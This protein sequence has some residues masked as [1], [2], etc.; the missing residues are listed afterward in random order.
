MIKARTLRINGQDHTIAIGHD[1]T[2]LD[3]LRD[4]LRLTGT[5]KGCNV[6]DCG[7]CTVHIDG[8]PMNSCLLL[9]SSLDGK[10]IT[11][12]EGIAE[13]GELTPLQKSFVG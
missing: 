3:V 7:V 5:K 13:N 12:I 2:L 8:V 1:E 11:T 6:G 4:A 9:A 10:E